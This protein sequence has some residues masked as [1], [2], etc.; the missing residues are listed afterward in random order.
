MRGALEAHVE[1]SGALAAIL[2]MVANS[3]IFAA[4]MTLPGRFNLLVSH[5]VT[6]PGSIGDVMAMTAG[7][8]AWLLFIMAMQTLKRLTFIVWG[9]ALARVLSSVSRMARKPEG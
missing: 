2:L 4:M 7:D 3:R 5:L 8:R 9:P 6:S 1:K